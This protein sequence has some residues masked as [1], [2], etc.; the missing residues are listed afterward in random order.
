M[1]HVIKHFRKG[2]AVKKRGA[3]RAIKL[4]NTQKEAIKFGT[5]LV[6][7]HKTMLYI[8]EEDGRVL[9]LVRDN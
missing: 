2:W 5:E 9:G 3:R 4:F 8:H 7:K 1:I 6:K